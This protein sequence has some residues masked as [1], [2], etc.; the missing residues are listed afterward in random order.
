MAA[1]TRSAGARGDRGFS[2]LIVMMAVL[3]MAISG[4]AAISVSGADNTAAAG[5]SARSQARFAAESGM[6]GFFDANPMATIADQRVNPLGGDF[7]PA[8]GTLYG[9]P[10]L[11]LSVIDGT[12]Y[13]L[14]QRWWGTGNNA[15]VTGELGSSVGAGVIVEGR[16][17]AQVGTAPEQV[18]G[19]VWL[20]TVTRRCERVS[21]YGGVGGDE[22]GTGT[23]D[24]TTPLCPFTRF[25][26]T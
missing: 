25:E 3:V 24:E 11:D 23:S 18:I 7:G 2:L 15:A 16:L 9:S 6:I 5:R 20:G 10:P 26:G 1:S 8:A 19:R 13:R 22:G 21:D 14:E 4:A 12:T 17:V